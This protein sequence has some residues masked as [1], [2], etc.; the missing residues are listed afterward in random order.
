MGKDVARQASQSLSNLS[1]TLGNSHRLVPK[2]ETKQTVLHCSHANQ[3]NILH[4][5]FR[6][7]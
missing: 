5:R 7:H 4:E 1:A 2:K 3:P 6:S